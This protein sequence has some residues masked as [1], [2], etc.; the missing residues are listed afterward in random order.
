MSY[1]PNDG[2]VFSPLF[3]SK[4]KMKLYFYTLIIIQ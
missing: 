1:E 2:S 4:S 3:D